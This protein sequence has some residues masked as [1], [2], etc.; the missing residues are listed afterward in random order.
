MG[1]KGG[2]TMD[3]TAKDMVL[4]ILEDYSITNVNI[5]DGNYGTV[6]VTFTAKEKPVE[7]IPW[8]DD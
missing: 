8:L 6:K 2:F 5:K 4:K 7:D 3:L 1:G